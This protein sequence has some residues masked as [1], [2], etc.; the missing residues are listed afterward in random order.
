MYI[1]CALVFVD[2]I[3]P[4]TFFLLLGLLFFSH[5]NVRRWTFESQ[6]WQTERVV[7]GGTCLR[8][9]VVVVEPVHKKMGGGV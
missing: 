5:P 9:G 8:E 2:T 6:H 1:V 7:G 3:I 4:Q